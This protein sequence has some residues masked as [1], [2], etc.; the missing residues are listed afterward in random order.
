MGVS[1]EMVLH[2]DACKAH[3][4]AF[5]SSLLWLG[6]KD[7]NENLHEGG[8]CCQQN[9][10]GRIARIAMKIG[11]KEDMDVADEMILDLVSRRSRNYVQ[12]VPKRTYL[13]YTVL[14][15]ENWDENMHKG[16]H[17]HCH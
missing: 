10:N 7:C 13:Q 15:G 9:G 3:L 14:K 11:R 5:I 4:N 8:H 6:V 16:G 2:V 1:D 17:C 12:S